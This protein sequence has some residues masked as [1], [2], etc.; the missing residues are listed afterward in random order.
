MTITN[1]SIIDG[2]GVPARRGQVRVVADSIA[3]VGDSVEQA[4]D[5]IIDGHGLTLAPGFIDTHS[6]HTGGLLQA[7]DA[8]AAVSQGITTV[9]GG[10]D[11][12]QPFP[13]AGARIRSWA[14]WA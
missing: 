2:T 14:S 12:S 9:I 13:L 6:H 1:V 3:A 10:Q 7:R 8:L 11:G 4:G 5:A